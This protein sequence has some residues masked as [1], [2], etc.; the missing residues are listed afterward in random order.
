MNKLFRSYLFILLRN[1]LTWFFVLA[2]VLFVNVV[3]YSVYFI[4]PS[5]SPDVFYQMKDFLSFPSLL[6]HIDFA[7]SIHFSLVLGFFY[8][9][10]VSGNEYIWHT[11]RMPLLLGH[12]RWKIVLSK[13]LVII[14]IIFV[15]TL[16]ASLTAALVG[17]LGVKHANFPVHLIN[18][19]VAWLAIR[20]FLIAIVGLAVYMALDVA[21]STSTRSSLLGFSLSLL[22]FFLEMFFSS[23]VMPVPRLAKYSLYFNYFNLVLVPEG[24]KYP[25]FHFPMLI[26]VCVYGLL[27]I[28]WMVLSFQHQQIHE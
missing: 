22:V 15:A 16:F 17:F 23:M 25:T 3:I 21:I 24:Y 14:V 12:P 28:L 27:F 7:I 9:S 20:T 4:Y 13:Y 8:C 2:L 6:F 19:E 11:I 18:A 26:A 10:M 1:K 5:F